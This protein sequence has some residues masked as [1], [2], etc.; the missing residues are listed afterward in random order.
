MRFARSKSCISLPIYAT[1]GKILPGPILHSC[2]GRSRR[3]SSGSPSSPLPT[4]A[5]RRSNSVRSILSSETQRPSGRPVAARSY[6]VR[7]GLAGRSWKTVEEA[8]RFGRPDGLQPR[9]HHLNNEIVGYEASFRDVGGRLEAEGS[10]SL[11]VPQSAR[12]SG[13]LASLSRRAPCSGWSLENS[14][15]GATSFAGVG[16][17]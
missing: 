16:R 1:L 8:T 5:S 13:S 11:G 6:R 2:S 4:A 7:I 15:G 9:G 3:P 10:P 12:H 14:H 17:A